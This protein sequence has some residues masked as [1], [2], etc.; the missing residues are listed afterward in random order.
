[1]WPRKSGKGKQEWTKACIK[2][3]IQPRKLNK[4][5]KTR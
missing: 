2:S 3:K 5:I 4:H 1:M